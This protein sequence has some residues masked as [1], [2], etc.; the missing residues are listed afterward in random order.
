MTALAAS[1]AEER[2]GGNVPNGNSSNLTYYVSED[3]PIRNCDSVRPI[4]QGA[5]NEVSHALVGVVQLCEALSVLD[6]HATILDVVCLDP[7]PE[8][9]ILVVL[10]I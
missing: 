9:L 4:V 6:G 8:A 5:V 7:G 1:I 10:H 2:N 3:T